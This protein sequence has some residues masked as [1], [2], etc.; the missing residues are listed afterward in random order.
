MPQAYVNYSSTPRT[1]VHCPLN[2]G[3][4]KDCEKYKSHRNRWKYRWTR[5]ASQKKAVAFAKK[6]AK[7]H[8]TKVHNCGMS[9]CVKG[10]R[11]R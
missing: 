6:H 5:F 7:S 11:A 8:G 1:I 4:K 9:P 2:G 3:H 10:R